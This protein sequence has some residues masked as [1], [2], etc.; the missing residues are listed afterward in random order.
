MPLYEITIM[1][2]L[3]AAS[4]SDAWGEALDVLHGRK[5][6]GWTLNGIEAQ[7]VEEEDDE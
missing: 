7:Q 5:P 3:E 1:I 6:E 2:T 4:E